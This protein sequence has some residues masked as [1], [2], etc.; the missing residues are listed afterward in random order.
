[1]HASGEGRGGTCTVAPKRQRSVGLGVR[2]TRY[3]C[4]PCSCSALSSRQG[5]ACA[6]VSSKEP[7]PPADLGHVLAAGVSGPGRLRG[8]R[9][10]LKP[11]LIVKDC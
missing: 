8:H 9:L 10:S 1:M 11:L 7:V 2:S 6:L 4:A 5:A 3:G